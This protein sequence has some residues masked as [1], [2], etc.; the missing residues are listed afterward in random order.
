MTNQDAREPTMTQIAITSDASMVLG[1]DRWGDIGWGLVKHGSEEDAALDL[2]AEPMAYPAALDA[3]RAALGDE[4]DVFPR[5]VAWS[6]EPPSE[7]SVSAAWDLYRHKLVAVRIAG[8]DADGVEVHRI[9]RCPAGEVVADV[10]IDVTEVGD[11]EGID[12]A[13]GSQGWRVLDYT[14]TVRSF[15]GLF[16]REVE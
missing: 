3:A 6:S 7:E 8:P 13:L 1:P 16:S 14:E 10:A 12:M 15:D 11:N 5:G 2:P 4:T 9:I